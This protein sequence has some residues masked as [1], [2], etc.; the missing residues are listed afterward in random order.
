MYARVSTSPVP[1]SCTTH[2][3]SPRSSKRISVSPVIAGSL[4]ASPRA[5]H[6][7][8]EGWNAYAREPSAPR[9][10]AGRR[11]RRTGLGIPARGA[12]DAG[13]VAGGAHPAGL[14]RDRVP[15]DRPLRRVAGAAHRRPRLPA[16]GEALVEGDADP[17]R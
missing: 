17:V 13:A 3:T 12:A 2:G 8:C 10:V 15:R 6:A 4:G 1:Q 9:A 7:A 5:S 11:S 16:T 14:L